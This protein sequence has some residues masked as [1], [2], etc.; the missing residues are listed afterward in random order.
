MKRKTMLSDVNTL[1]RKSYKYTFVGNDDDIEKALKVVK[2][3]L[4]Y[5]CSNEYMIDYFLSN[6]IKARLVGES[7]R[8]ILYDV[9]NESENG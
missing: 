3:L 5:C 6:G 8:E 1:K 2:E 7:D 4:I 9:T